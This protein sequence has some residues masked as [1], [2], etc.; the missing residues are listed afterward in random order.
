VGCLQSGIRL[1]PW[2][3]AVVCLAIMMPLDILVRLRLKKGGEQSR[4]FQGGLFNHAKYLRPRRQHHWSGW[5][6]YLIWVVWL[7]GIVLMLLNLL[8]NTVPRHAGFCNGDVSP[9]SFSDF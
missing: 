5:P 4:P 6:V 1:F 8:Y 9:T 3:L 2:F 7:A